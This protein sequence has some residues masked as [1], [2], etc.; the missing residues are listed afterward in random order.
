VEAQILE[1]SGILGINA[2][3]SLPGGASRR[4]GFDKIGSVFIELHNE[5]E[6]DRSATEILEE[7]R[8]R[9][10]GFSGIV[11]EL[12]EMQQGPHGGKPIEI[13]F[14]SHTKEL[15]EPAVTRVLDHINNEMTG[16]RDL[17]DTRSLPGIEW[18]LTVDRAQAAL[19]GADVSQVG[20]AVQL[21]TDGVK[22]GEYRP[23]KADDAVDIR[24][25]YPATARGISALDELKIATSNGLVPISNFV[26]RTAA[27][28]VDAIQRIDGTPVEFIR[29][30]VAP[31]VL[32]DTKVKELSAWVEAQAWDPRLDIEFR[33]TNEEQDDAMAFVS[34]AFAMSMLLMFVLLVTQFNSFYQSSLIL[35]AVVLST[36]GVLLGLI[37][38]GKPFSAILTGV[39]IVALAGIVVNNNIVL[40]DTYNHLRREHPEL[41]YISLIVRTGAQRLRPVILTTATTVFGLLPLA[42]NFSIDLINRN[43]IYG[44]MMSSFWVPLSQSIVSGLT[45]ATVLTLVATPAMLALPH[46]LKFMLGRVKA[47]IRAKRTASAA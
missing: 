8:E 17:D 12:E 47:S 28:N 11:V 24:V 23:D 45:F 39:G 26:T 44:G 33:G 15:L 13:Q 10:R 2:S 41:D 46:Q 31:G 4:G 18:K 16:M 1:V 7:I 40:I 29:A 36:A 6:R 30:N 27:P 32:A 35:F 9:T 38:T 22:V 43:I 34:V 25:R 19:Y 42:S 14:S 3:T 20:I 21:L 37:I 5:N